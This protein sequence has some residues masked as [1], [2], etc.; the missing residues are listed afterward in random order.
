MSKQ[1]WE[2]S[3]AK[4]PSRSPSP[5]PRGGK[6]KAS[7][8]GKSTYIEPNRCCEEFLKS[9]RCELLN[10]NGECPK[11]HLTQKDLDREN[12]DRDR[13]KGSAKGKAD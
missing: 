3:K 13:L 8:K 10:K 2:Q 12:K 1:D 9:G 6:A 4:P 7:G 11:L 5:A